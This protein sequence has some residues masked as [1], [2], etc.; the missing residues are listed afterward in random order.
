MSD[1]EDVRDL[2][3]YA[4]RV[5]KRRSGGRLVRDRALEFSRNEKIAGTIVT[6]AI[7][8]PLAIFLPVWISED[9][10][11]NNARQFCRDAAHEAGYRFIEYDV[12]Y[13]ECWA[14]RPDGSV[15]DLNG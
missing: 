8:I 15:V 5:D 6:L 3:A 13:E 10:A 7:I 2:A 12:L 1:P 9:V 14:Q 4:R 11:L